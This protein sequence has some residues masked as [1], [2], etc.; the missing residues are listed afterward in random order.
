MAFDDRTLHPDSLV[1]DVPVR[2][3]DWLPRN[4]DRDHQGAVTVRRAL[5]QSLNV[6]AVLA[7]ER[8][9]A[10]RFLA[11]LRAAGANPILAPGDPGTSLG[12]ALGS[13]T[14]SPLEMAGLYAGLANG[15]RFAPPQVRR[16]QP[17]PEPVKL[18]GEAAA[19]YVADVLADAPL[20]D[21]FASLPVALRERRVA[22]KTGTSAGFRDA[23]AAGFSANWTVVVWV[24][25]ADGT[26]RPGQ[27]GRV[28]ALPILFKAFGRLPGEDNRATRP[29]AD[30][31]RVGSWQ[32]LPPR[33]RRL[34]PTQTEGAPRIAYP[35]PD[36]RLELGT[37][38]TVTLA[39]SGNGRLRWL[40]DGRP[41]DGTAWTPEGAGEMRLAVVDDAG[42]S[43]AVTVRVVR[44]Q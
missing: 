35:P 32:E 43:S 14:V 25:H 1:E 7:L 22:Y 12:M 34:A 23:W 16:D 17:Q 41:L 40:V 39:A 15:G 44:R 19:W 11:T 38:E 3:K 5:Q 37:R 28:S 18:V 4:F 13:A 2:F 26:P 10:A 27:L 36:A 8:V 6:P 24:G 29:P 9:G 21:G 31:L 42:R 30:V 20:P 33:M